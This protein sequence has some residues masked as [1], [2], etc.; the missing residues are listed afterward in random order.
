MHTQGHARTCMQMCSRA[1]KCKW[2]HAHACVARTCMQLHAYA[3][4]FKHD[5]C[6][7]L[8]RDIYMLAQK[9][10]HAHACTRRNMHAHAC[11]C[12]HMPENASGCMHMHALR[13][14]AC[15]RNKNIILHAHRLMR[16]CMHRHAHA[17]SF[18]NDMRNMILY[19]RIF[20]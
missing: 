12:F 11:R 15:S 5:A 20:H 17:C 19:D 14:H 6:I 2:V 10:P 13:V 18:R 4:A 1:R 16:T 3:S 7:C 8:R 9:S